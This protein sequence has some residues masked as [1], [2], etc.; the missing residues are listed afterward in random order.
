[1][2]D[3]DIYNERRQQLIDSFEDDPIGLMDLLSVS[4]SILVDAL[5]WED[6][7]KLADFM[8]WIETDS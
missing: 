5:D 8:G 2:I 6:N 3:Y 4:I 1:M 7:E